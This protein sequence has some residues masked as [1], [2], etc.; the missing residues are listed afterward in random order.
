[1]HLNLTMHMYVQ[2]YFK[3]FTFETVQF[4]IA[5]IILNVKKG[6]ELNVRTLHLFLWL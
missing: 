1:M 5:I 3:K 4:D 6:H 2:N